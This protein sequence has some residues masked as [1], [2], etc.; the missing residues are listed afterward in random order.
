MQAHA[1]FGAAGLFFD[2]IVTGRVPRAV[3]L[4]PL[5]RVMVSN[6]SILRL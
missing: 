1:R 6:Y 3:A 2:S 4:A 5:G